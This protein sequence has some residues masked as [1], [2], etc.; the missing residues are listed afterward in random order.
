MPKCK[1]CKKADVAKAKQGPAGA[2]RVAG[3][4]YPCYRAQHPPKAKTASTRGSKGAPLRL[5]A[6]MAKAFDELEKLVA[7]ALEGEA[8][9]LLA[10][11]RELLD[12]VY[13]WFGEL[14]GRRMRVAQI[15]KALEEKARTS[16]AEVRRELKRLG[17]A[18]KEARAEMRTLPRIPEWA[19]GEDRG[20]I[21]K[22]RRRTKGK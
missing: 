14:R 16:S 12:R 13:L 3:L 7:N 11:T 19:E 8:T 9:A 20:D 4:C 5:S 10:D 15:M 2:A 6:G 17:G 21:T 22:P 1:Q 18:R